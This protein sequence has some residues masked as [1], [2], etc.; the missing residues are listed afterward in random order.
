MKS[1]IV[2]KTM[3][4]TL[5][6]LG[7]CF[8]LSFT[9][10]G[11]KLYPQWDKT[12]IQKYN[13]PWMYKYKL[14]VYVREVSFENQLNSSILKMHYNGAVIMLLWRLNFSN[15][16]WSHL[17]LSFCMP[18]CRITNSWFNTAQVVYMIWNAVNDPLFG[19][20]QVQYMSYVIASLL[21]MLLQTSYK[22]FHYF[23]SIS[24]TISC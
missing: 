8:L 6:N 11:P 16:F 20:L 4:I 15:C 2:I 21:I 14:F 23:P 1:W 10:F 12:W 7:Y 5:T 24:Y 13:I 19:Y 9:M 3:V 18:S 17:W 22:Y